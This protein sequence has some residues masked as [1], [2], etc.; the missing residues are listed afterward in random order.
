MSAQEIERTLL[1]LDS[2]YDFESNEFYDA[3]LASDCEQI[4]CSDSDSSNSQSKD[5]EAGGVPSTSTASVRPSLPPNF[6]NAEWDWAPGDFTPNLF[7]FDSSSSGIRAS[8][9]ISDDSNEL[10]YFTMF[11]DESVMRLI[12]TET[13]KQY[14]FTKSKR[15]TNPPSY[16]DRWRNVTVEEL[17]VFLGL[18]LLMSHVEKREIS[19][20]WST[21]RLIHTPIYSKVMPKSRYLMI[22]KMLHFSDNTVHSRDVLCKIRPIYSYMKKKF[23]EVFYPFKNVVIDESF[24]LFKGRLACKQYIPGKRHRIG[25]KIFVLCDCET[26]FVMDFM[27]YTGGSR[28]VTARHHLGMAG[29]VVQKMMEPYYDKGHCLFVGDWY[30]SPQL[31]YF[32]YSKKVGACGTVRSNMK[33]FPKFGHAPRGECSTLHANNILSMKWHDTRDVHMLTTIHEGKLIDTGKKERTG[34]NVKKPEAVLDYT[35]N[36]RL[37]NKAD[38]Q[39]GN[40]ATRGRTYK[41][42]RKLFFHIVDIGVLNSYN[43]FLVKSG[44]RPKYREFRLRLIRQIIEKFGDEVQSART[45]RPSEEGIDPTRLQLRKGH[46]L[47]ILPSREKKKYPQKRCLVCSTTT[48]KPQRRRETRYC[49]SICDVPLCL[50]PCFEEYHTLKSF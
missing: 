13:N 46:F 10:E 44:M 47:K 26:G 45:G 1:H 32:L 28:E 35:K 8:A 27:I 23:S 24:I 7:A 9:G 41:W 19:E 22:S 30:S 17:Y 11:F 34:E 31:F 14:I 48:R 3:D 43:M 29:A 33:Y 42:Y 21:D 6:V 20:Y 38:M 2:E 18:C 25:M 16:L 39:C 4:D 15:E 37:V 50:I 49:C 5:D 40:A 12:Q 36:L